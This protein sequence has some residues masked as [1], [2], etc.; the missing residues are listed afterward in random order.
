MEALQ[1][2]V[3]RDP[4]ALVDRRLLRDPEDTCELVLERADPVGV[5]VARGEHEA[6]PAPRDEWVERRL[7][8]VVAGGRSV[9][10]VTLR[11]PQ[12]SVERGL[13]EDLALLGRGALH[14]DLVQLGERGVELLALART[15][16]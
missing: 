2:L 16:D 12:P 1:D 9:G 8:A 4:E 7:R 14:E 13:L 6:A 10:R 11:V 15:L 5:D 3:Q